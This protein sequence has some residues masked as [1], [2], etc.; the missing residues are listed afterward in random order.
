M[1]SPTRTRN[2]D[3]AKVVEKIDLV[4]LALEYGIDLI[5]QTNS[6]YIC[7]CPFHADV[8]PSMRIYS[9]TNS[10][11]CFGCQAG[12]SIFEFVMRM[13]NIEFKDALYR[14]AERAG[15]NSIFVLRDIE[16]RQID[17]NFITQ[18]DKIEKSLYTHAK[19]IYNALQETRHI[20]KKELSGEIGISPTA[21]DKNISTLK[22]KGLLKRIGPDK[23]GRWEVIK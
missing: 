1:E 5:Q 11:H 17:E 23:G 21:I 7:L 18:R 12:S 4:S 2:I 9:A 6:E 19:I 20:S 8:N 16:I 14:L 10:F 22:K 13:E 15:Y 3:V